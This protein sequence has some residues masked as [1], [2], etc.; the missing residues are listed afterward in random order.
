MDALVESGAKQAS[1]QAQMPPKVPHGHKD[2]NLGINVNPV[3]VPEE[4][5]S[6]RTGAEKVALG[7]RHSRAQGVEITKGGSVGSLDLSV[8]L[9]PSA[10]DQQVV[11]QGPRG[12]VHGSDEVGPGVEEERHHSHAQRATLGDGAGVEVRF[13]ETPTHSV[14]L[15][16]GGME[17][18]VSSEGT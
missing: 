3:P 5:S 6:G 12:A 16:A 2:L 14:V 9:R 4:G 8:M 15:E 18:G 1:P 13:P 7:G 10:E 11:G 17:V